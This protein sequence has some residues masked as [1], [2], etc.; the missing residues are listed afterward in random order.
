MEM[1][2]KRWENM[3]IFLLLFIDEAKLVGKFTAI[4]RTNISLTFEQMCAAVR[5]DI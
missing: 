3:G 1:D 2:E 5:G 4:F